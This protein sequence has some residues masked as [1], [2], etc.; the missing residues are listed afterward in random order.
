MV[1]ENN[2]AIT[3]IHKIIVAPLGVPCVMNCSGFMGGG[4]SV[5]VSTMIVGYC[6]CL[7]REST[8]RGKTHGQE[9]LKMVLGNFAFI[10][11]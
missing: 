4:L 5:L 6:K 8:L 2:T 9:L 11:F 10:I 7:V 1:A 3:E